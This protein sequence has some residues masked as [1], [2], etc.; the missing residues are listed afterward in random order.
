MTLAFLMEKLSIIPLK[1]S[2]DLPISIVVDYR[3]TLSKREVQ[4]V[5]VKGHG[6]RKASQDMTSRPSKIICQEL[7]SIEKVTGKN[8]PESV[9]SNDV[10]NILLVMYRERRNIH[11]PYQKI[12]LKSSSN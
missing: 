7:V 2:M 5:T 6:K 1:L 9:V 12:L 4:S 8:N 10:V 3:P 11:Q